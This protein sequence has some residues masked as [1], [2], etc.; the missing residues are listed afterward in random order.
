[1]VFKERTSLNFKQPNKL[2]VWNNMQSAWLLSEVAQL[3]LHV[4]G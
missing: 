4:E 1:M 2:R 3:V